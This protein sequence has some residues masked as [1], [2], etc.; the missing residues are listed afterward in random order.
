[1]QPWVKKLSQASYSLSRYTLVCIGLL[2][3]TLPIRSSTWP[4]LLERIKASGEL[5]VASRNGPTTYYQGAE[6][7][8]GFD[9]T[10]LKGF[11]DELG[12][13][14][15]IIEEGDLGRIFRRIE[16]RDIHMGAA[17][18]T[19][20]QKRSKRADFSYPYLQVTQQLIYRANTLKP[21]SIADIV[22]QKILVIGNSSHAE[23]LR[24]LKKTHPDLSWQEEHDI[25]MLDLMEKVHNG[26]ITY[27]VV[28]SNALAMNAN[29]YPKA[30]VA[31]DITEPQPLAWALPKTPDT[32]LKEAANTY[33]RKMESSGKLSKITESFYGHVGHI[34]YSGALLFAKRLK[35]RF[36][37]WKEYIQDAAQENNLDWQLLAALSYQESHWNPKAKSPTGVRGFMMLT[38]NTAKEM[39]VTSRIDAKQSIYG[40]ARYFRKMYDRLSPSIVEPDRTWLAL[41]S[42]NIGFYH[43]QDARKIT[44]DQGGNPNLWQDV[45]ERL[46]LLTKRQFYKKTRFGYARGHEAV[47]YVNNIRNFYNV[48]EWKEQER[49]EEEARKNDLASDAVEYE[50]IISSALEELEDINAM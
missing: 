41:A 20:T 1:M 15:T 36:P 33:L 12:I 24:S 3:L 29:V 21:Q 5:I 43:L 35:T 44:Q 4:T 39:G 32:S 6:G 46:P 25:E 18:L 38:R 48:I 10:L 16:K 19:V 47:G 17:G 42:Y 9:Y 37:K 11:A 22:G 2:V 34:D 45:R 23:Q 40:G 31:F 7:Y 49:I 30:M 50:S 13:E 8:T 27:A 14:L 26:D 28:D